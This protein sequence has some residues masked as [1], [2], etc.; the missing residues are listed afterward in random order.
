MRPTL[1][2]AKMMIEDYDLDLSPQQVFGSLLGDF[3]TRSLEAIRITLNAAG[4]F[5]GDNDLLVLALHERLTKLG[6]GSKRLTP[7]AELEALLATDKPT[8]MDVARWADASMLVVYT[9]LNAKRLLVTNPRKTLKI[10]PRRALSVLAAANVLQ[11]PFDDPAWTTSFWQNRTGKQFRPD[12]PR[13][14]I[15]I[16]QRQV[17]TLAAK[18]ARADGK[19]ELADKINQQKVFLLKE[20]A[21][22]PML[23]E[24]APYIIAAMDQLGYWP[25]NI[26]DLRETYE[27]YSQRYAK[28]IARREERRLHGV[29][30]F[31]EL[32]RKGV[33]YDTE[34]A[35]YQR[36]VILRRRARREE[37]PPEVQ[38]HVAQALYRRGAPPLLVEGFA[39]TDVAKEVGVTEMSAREVI[40]LD[41]EHI[42][43]T[44]FVEY[45][46]GMRR[47]GLSEI[48]ALWYCERYIKKLGL[49]RGIELDDLI[50]LG[51]RRTLDVADTFTQ[52]S[53]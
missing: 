45:V 53:E 7:N 12:P 31:A 20:K 33:N 27:R 10:H 46:V 8:Q 48:G 13:K 16:T 40:N 25:Q 17:A 21:L 28:E 2:D 26:P 51:E 5:W 43:P 29:G 15:G 39:V 1:R 38:A 23:I 9:A 49:L 19:H 32:K 4:K 11:F 41:H 22:L 6:D 3:R 50:Y 24:P 35:P 47:I 14:R 52:A 42:L 37:L 36:L 18:L 44:K 30:P 34:G